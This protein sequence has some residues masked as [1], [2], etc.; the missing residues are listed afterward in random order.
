L[1]ID[2]I[3]AGANHLVLAPIGVP[4]SWLA[5]EVVKPVLAAGGRPG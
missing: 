1:L 4:L 5:D 2:F 3:G